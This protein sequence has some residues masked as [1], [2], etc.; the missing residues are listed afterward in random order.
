MALFLFFTVNPAAWH[1]TA[2]GEWKKV[3]PNFG[4]TK[5]SRQILVWHQSHAKIWRDIE[6]MPICGFPYPI[7]LHAF[8]RWKFTPKIGVT[9]SH[10][11][12]LA[13]LPCHTK[14]LAWLLCHAVFWRDFLSRQNLAWCHADGFTVH[15]SLMCAT[16]QI[17]ISNLNFI[18]KSYLPH[19]ATHDMS[20]KIPPK[21]Q[22]A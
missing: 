5:K 8:G 2:S 15:W 14:F 10:A 17:W 20:D 21:H 6:I 18:A 9:R 13:W 4:V 22:K 12:C 19:L 3:T 1:N 7:R 11:E 16:R